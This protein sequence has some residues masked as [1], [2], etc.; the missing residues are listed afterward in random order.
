MSIPT[1]P[2]PTIVADVV[3]A[4]AISDHRVPGISPII[5]DDEAPYYWRFTGLVMCCA[6]RGGLRGGVRSCP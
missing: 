6:V 1:N 3:A 4:D 5:D 2:L